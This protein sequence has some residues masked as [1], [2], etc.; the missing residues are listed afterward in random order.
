M[1][2]TVEIY[3]KKGCPFCKEAKKIISRVHSDLPF[4]F[5][6]VD[7]GANADLS[8]RFVDH[9]PIIYINGKKAF[10]FKVDEIEFRKKVRKELIKAGISKI[11]E[12]RGARVEGPPVRWKK[13]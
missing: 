10:K 2:T 8:R 5:K 1:A 4:L 11:I 9:V 12:G 6:E 3:S 13:Q 7:I